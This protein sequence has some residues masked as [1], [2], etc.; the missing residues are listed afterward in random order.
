MIFYTN[1]KMMRV[2]WKEINLLAIYTMILLPI[3]MA[4]I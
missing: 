3:M 1:G 4:S 2:Y